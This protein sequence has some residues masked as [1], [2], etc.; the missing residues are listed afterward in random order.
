M[1]FQESPV[2]GSVFR[3]LLFFMAVG[4][5]MTAPS[6]TA[7]TL[8]PYK[9]VVDAENF[10]LK[11]VNGK[12]FR[13]SSLKDKVVLLNFWA[14]WCPPCKKEMP[15]MERLYKEFKLSGF[16]V[17]AVALDKSSPAT[18]KEFI[19]EMGVS[20]IALHDPDGITSNLYSVS[21]V[22]YSYLVTR[23]SKIAFRVAGGID[24]DDESVKSIVK[25]LL[26]EKK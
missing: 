2:N 10:H 19:K 8:I 4:M 11:S 9:R 3:A 5:A 24:W 17:V 13:F 18:V 12:R 14:T 23:E 1:N 25:D 16:E 6:S 26:L 7:Q 20:F 15:S 22:P 21:G